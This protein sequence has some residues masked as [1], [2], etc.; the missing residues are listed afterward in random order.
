MS[1]QAQL[2]SNIAFLIINPTLA[3]RSK[4]GSSLSQAMLSWI[5]R[6]LFS[7]GKGTALRD[8]VM[9][10]SPELTKEIGRPS[11]YY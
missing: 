9:E 3:V 10:Q 1:P 2:A 7:P 4:T 5:E 8:G 6:I 11:R